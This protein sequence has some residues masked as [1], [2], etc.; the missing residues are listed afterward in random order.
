[1]MLS[2]WFC[3]IGETIFTRNVLLFKSQTIRIVYR[4]TRFKHKKNGMEEIV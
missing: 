3:V 2:I 1:M 4:E